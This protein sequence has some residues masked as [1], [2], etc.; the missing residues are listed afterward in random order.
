MACAAV[1]PGQ[2]IDRN[3]RVTVNIAGQEV[4]WGK[5]DEWKCFAYYI[6]ANKATNPFLPPD[7]LKDI[8]D[9]DAIIKGRKATITPEEY[10]AVN[11]AVNRHYPNE[12]GGYNPPK[13]GGCLRACLNSMEKRGVITPQFANRFRDK[14]AWKLEN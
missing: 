6:G 2:C 5:L 11:D 13:C 9:G 7:A 3:E 10:P 4:S 14:E 1:C 12:P 8:P